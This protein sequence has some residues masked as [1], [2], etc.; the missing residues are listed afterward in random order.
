MKTFLGFIIGSQIGIDIMV[1]W[2]LYRIGKEL[3]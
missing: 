1:L 3:E 2:L